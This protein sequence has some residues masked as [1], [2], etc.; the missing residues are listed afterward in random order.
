MHRNLNAGKADTKSLNEVR[1]T[2]CKRREAETNAQKAGL[3][4]HSAARN[5]DCKLPITKQNAS[6]FDQHLAGSG[7]RQVTWPSDKERTTQC[8]L[9]FVDLL[10]KS[11]LGHVQSSGGTPEMEMFSENNNRAHLIQI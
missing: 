11:R 3:S 9:N 4:P 8:V 5:V 1:E 7:Q 6:V 2:G 10:G